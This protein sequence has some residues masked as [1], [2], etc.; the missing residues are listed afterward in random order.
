MKSTPHGGISNT[1]TKLVLAKL[2]RDPWL[3]LAY[4]AFFGV[5]LGFLCRPDV[6]D[7]YYVRYITGP[8][9]ILLYNSNYL[10]FFSVLLMGGGILI[11]K[12]KTQPFD[13]PNLASILFLGFRCML[14]LR[15]V[16]V[17]FPPVTEL[18]TFTLITML[19][20]IFSQKIKSL[21][22]SKAGMIWISFF[23]VLEVFIYS[24]LNGYQLIVQPE[25]VE[26]VGRLHG[27]N[28]HS[29]EF[30]MSLGLLSVWLYVAIFSGRAWLKLLA[31]VTLLASAYF[32]FRSGSRSGALTFFVAGLPFVYWLLRRKPTWVIMA[33]VGGIMLLPFIWY[34]VETGTRELVESRL[35]STQN[36][37]AEVF[38]MMLDNFLA[39]PLFGNPLTAGGTSNSY[40][41]AASSTGIIGI[42]LMMG[43]L[44][45]LFRHTLRIHKLVTLSIPDDDLTLFSPLIWS[46]FLSI[47][48]SSAFSGYFVETMQFPLLFTLFHMAFVDKTKNSLERQRASWGKIVIG[49]KR[50]PI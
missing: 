4:M 10:V 38:R 8:V 6:A 18:V 35:T 12:L 48:A 17:G 13:F 44:W 5:M 27:L 9:A 32:V 21:D 42:V 29:N 14:A 30:S 23:I 15:R 36:T 26:N 50:K 43:A 1:I 24:I 19:I 37:R 47:I 49:G 46:A 11:I 25:S 45:L 34:Y 31:S 16:A 41:Y 40:L 33:G 3:L 2:F 28:S 7:S 22:E 20:L 39:N